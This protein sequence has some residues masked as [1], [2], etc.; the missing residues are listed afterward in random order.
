M[1]MDEQLA[2]EVI[3]LRLKNLTPKQI[4]RKLS[5]K[6]AEVSAI[7][8]TQSAALGDSR[9]TR[10]ALDPLCGCWV[11]SSFRLPFVPAN[12]LL[13]PKAGQ[14]QRVPVNYGRSQSRFLLNEGLATVTIAR[15]VSATKIKF[16][17]YLIDYHCLGVKDVVAPR[18]IDR[19]M[20][21]TCLDRVYKTEELGHLAISLPEAHAIIFS[22][23]EFAQQCGL[24]PHPD[25]EKAK[26]F[27]GPWD[28]SL[29]IEC[30]HNGKPVYCKSLYDSP[31]K[32]QKIVETL[33]KN[34]GQGNFETFLSGS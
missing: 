15:Q 28:R 11:S 13:R 5:L 17:S 7:L 6:P 30:G 27:L 20:L 16:A 22:A 33:N 25:F 12:K 10:T 26:D 29:Y 2:Q 18:T 4:A 34:V 32:A 21:S 3:S 8:N 23:L 9:P 31:R 19:T 14:L 24:A 1:S